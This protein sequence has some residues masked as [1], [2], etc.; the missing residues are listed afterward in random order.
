MTRARIFSAALLA[1]GAL[2]I[3]AAHA[4]GVAPAPPQG[5]RLGPPLGPQVAI[6]F[7]DLPAHASL[8]PGDT[9]MQVEAAIV[10][11]LKA[12]GAPPVY[13]F[14]NGVQLERE[15][16]S[17]PVLGAWRAAGFPLGNHTWSHMNLDTAPLPDWEA[18]VAKNEPLL[19]AQM[20]GADWRWLR[21]PYLAEG[22]TSQK[23][24]AAR[25]FLRAR[26]YRIAQV[27]MSFSDY[28]FN[29]PYAR[30]AAQGDA[31]TIARMEAAYLAGAAAAIDR[32]RA[33]AHAALGRDIPYVLLMHIGAF[34][35]R[36]AP[37]LMAL[38]RARRVRLVG[39]PQAEADRFYAPDLDLASTAPDTLEAALAAKGLPT[40]QA[41][42]L[43]WLDRA[44]R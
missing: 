41:A 31:A 10:S 39:L 42:D 13:G 6:T 19:K 5:P 33:M 2:L 7:D 14:V 28:A 1:T 18:D 32:S 3:G 4:A 9:R 37:R 29:D 20:A 27:T 38:Y 44:C 40:P 8:P 25:A 24:A 26:G 22:G 43:A 17:A 15:P 12:A 30:C 36:M 35:A 16:A 21:F 23:R 11:A 34:D